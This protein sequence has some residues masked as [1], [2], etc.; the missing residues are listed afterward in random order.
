MDIRQNHVR[1]LFEEGAAL[2]QTGNMSEALVRLQAAR[3]MEPSNPRILLY[4]GAALHGLKFFDDAL[5]CYE[6]ALHV[7]PDLGEVHNNRGNSLMA[8]G[9]FSEAVESYSLAASLLPGSPVPLAAGATALQ[10]LGRISKAEFNCRSA[11]ALDPAFAAAHWNL[12]LNLL[13]QGRYEEG[14]KEYE[15]RWLKPD[16]SSP[17]RHT[18]MPLWD[19]ST[20]AGRTILLHAEQGFGDAIQF[21]RYAPLVSQ[22]GGHV[23]LECHPQLVSLFQSVY[24]VQTAVPFGAPLP[25]FDCQIPLLSLPYL[26]KTS[27]QTIP[28][29]CPYV[30]VPDRYR[31]KWSV[32][33]ATKPKSRRIGLAWSGKSY[34]D[35]LRTCRLD[36]LA[37]LSV[38]E[39]TFFSLQLGEGAEQAASPPPGMNLID[40]TSEI[41]DFADTAALIE[42]LDLVISIDTAV[43]HLAGALGKPAFV[44][45][46]YAPDWRWMLDRSDSPWYPGMT[47]YR[48]D[49]SGDWGSVVCR[50]AAALKK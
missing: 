16:F 27:L 20:L 13:L 46:P 30:S 41:A 19:G 35:P 5:E 7:E 14:W 12:A 21:V 26:F 10:A 44:M 24:G 6:R 18:D 50:I 42:Q 15:W 25:H 33:T 48:Q 28:A 1:Q 32:L 47:L 2:L 29:H 45:L 34:P 8:L 37:A 11:L 23:V 31:E 9:R 40:L 17:C 49:V 22:R 38:G 36:E 43:A 39:I 4:T 3:K